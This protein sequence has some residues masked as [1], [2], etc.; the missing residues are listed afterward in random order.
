MLGFV[1]Q[2]MLFTAAGLGGLERAMLYVSLQGNLS[3][4][5]LPAP[6]PP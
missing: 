4:S 2:R 5:V 1:L 6:T 3:R